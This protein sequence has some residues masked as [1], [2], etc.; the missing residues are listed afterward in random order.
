MRANTG[1]QVAGLG[2]GNWTKG[3]LC[4]QLAWQVSR[5]AVPS[6]MTFARVLQ[7]ASRGK[8]CARDRAAPVMRRKTR[9]SPRAHSPISTLRRVHPSSN[10]WFCAREIDRFVSVDATRG[11]FFGQVLR[12][13]D[14][15]MESCAVHSVVV[16][17][18]GPTAPPPPAH[19]LE[20]PLSRD[21]YTC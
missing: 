5:S 6:F 17:V 19:T 1:V 15:L 14:G 3:L 8:T 16:G 13:R 4:L 10:K 9:I 21:G 2:V 11:H 12:T 7:A 20:D 18:Q